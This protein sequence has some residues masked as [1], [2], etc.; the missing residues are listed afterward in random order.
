MTRSRLLDV[1]ADGV[2][3]VGSSANRRPFALFKMTW[4]TA[5]VNS[6]PDSSFAYVEP[7]AGTDKS[8]RHL[9]YK[10][11]NG[12]VDLPHL[13]NALARLDQTQIPAAAKA[14]ARGKLEAAARAAGIGAQKAAWD[15]AY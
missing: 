8:K 4:T 10:D 14:K 11:T 13:R 12:K 6:L 5:Y 7:G 1:D 3:L 2:D 9:P 15:T